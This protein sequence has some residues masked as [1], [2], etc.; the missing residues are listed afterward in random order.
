VK[1]GKRAGIKEFGKKI[2]L[3]SDSA[4]KL[5]LPIVI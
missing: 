1:A 4:L 3:C 2:I 5:T